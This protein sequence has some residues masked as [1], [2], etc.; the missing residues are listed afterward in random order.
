METKE[1]IAQLVIAV[2]QEIFSEDEAMGALP[3]TI[4]SPL[5]GRGGNIDSFTLVRIVAE[6]ED[7]VNGEFLKNIT[8][9]D[10]K[11]M[12]Q[13]ISPFRSVRALTEYISALLNEHE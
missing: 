8:L 2:I 10:E 3:I 5:Y 7:R 11:A 6:I 13:K 9:A 12:S 4:D 1:R